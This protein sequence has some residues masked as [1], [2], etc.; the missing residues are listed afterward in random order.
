MVKIQAAVQVMARSL[1][2]AVGVM[3]AVEVAGFL[4]AF[5]STFV[6]SATCSAGSVDS[7][8]RDMNLVRMC[9]LLG[10]VDIAGS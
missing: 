8:D 10:S 6:Y 5:L 4:V 2:T 9:S 7:W 1:G 3:T